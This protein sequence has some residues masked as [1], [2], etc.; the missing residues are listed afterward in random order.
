[1][2]VRALVVAAALAAPAALA[3]LVVAAPAQAAPRVAVS[4]EFGK[5]QADPTYLTTLSLRGTGFQAIKNGYGGIY[6]FFGTVRGKWRPSQ[7]GVTGED[8][9]YV[10]DSESKNNQG[11]QKF[12]A[13]EGSD[14][15]GAAQGIMK[16]DGSWSTTINIPGAKFNT[17]DR[18]GN[19]TSIDCLKVTC[20]IITIGA[21]GVKNARNESFTPITFA[22]LYDGATTTAPTTSPSDAATSPAATET[23]VSTAAPAPSGGTTPPAEPGGETVAAGPASAAVDPDTAV[24]GRVLSFTGTG[25]RPG[26]QVTASFDS[27]RAAV[28][29]LAAGASGEVAG[30]IQLPPDIR[31][32]THT[33]RLT[34]AASGTK[35]D[36]NF[37]IVADPAASSSAPTS[38]D[39]DET[40]LVDRLP[41]WSR[42]VFLGLAALVLVLAVLFAARR[43]RTIRAA[44]VQERTH[45][46]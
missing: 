30:V 41:D 38:G 42:W 17:V 33:L 11:F 14:T 6:V 10:P 28:G 37:P 24:L 5:A 8:Y 45:A 32:G 25:F 43:F 29:P 19:V 40:A 7:G 3:P 22:D 23:P 13:F 46:A 36:L 2:R 9:F 12:I 21:H 18:N 35:A 27:G 1:V 4:N 34:G 39:A 20:G 44:R 15:A 16:A 26:E 31:P